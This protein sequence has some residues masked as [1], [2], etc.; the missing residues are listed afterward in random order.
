MTATTCLMSSPS[1]WIR[2]GS[3]GWAG[4]APIESDE[5]GRTDML[6]VGDKAPIF[7]A[8]GTDGDVDLSALLA[9]GPVVLYFFPKAFTSG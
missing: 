4:E 2:T 8:A 3:T 7:V 1:S 6:K 5:S 9:V